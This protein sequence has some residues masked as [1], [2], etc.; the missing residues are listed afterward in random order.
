MPEPRII[1][2]KSCFPVVV[3]TMRAGYGKADIAHMLAEYDLLLREGKRYALIVHFP[4][5]VELLRAAQ[6]RE[7]ADWWLPRKELVAR[8]NAVTVTILQSALLRGAYTALLWLVQPPNPQKAVASLPEAID[9][10]VNVLE[11]EGTPLSP[12]IYALCA[13]FAQE[14]ASGRG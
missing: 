4:L 5:D 12:A 7:V 9:I 10:C 13:K 11:K 14:K 2:D 1:I 8:V 3:Q 6:R